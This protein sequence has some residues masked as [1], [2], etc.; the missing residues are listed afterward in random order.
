MA[1]HPQV[2]QIMQNDIDMVNDVTQISADDFTPDWNRMQCRHDCP[3][4]KNTQYCWTRTHSL[5]GLSE[6]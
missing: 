5:V 1:W 4:T 6:L 3:Y 2:L